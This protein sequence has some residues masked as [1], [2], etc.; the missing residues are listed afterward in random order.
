MWWEGNKR[1]EIRKLNS[2]DLYL[3]EKREGERERERERER[4][5]IKY[6]NHL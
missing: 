3:R 6:K 2:S 1:A 5:T 4:E